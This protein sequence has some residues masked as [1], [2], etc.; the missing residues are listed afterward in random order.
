MDIQDGEVCIIDFKSSNIRKKEKA[1]K[2]TRESLQLAIYA[3][4]YQKI[5]GKIPD[6]VELHFLE[7]GLIG[8]AG[9]SEDDL[10]RTVKKIDKAAAGIRVRLYEAKPAYLACRYCAYEK[11]C[12]YTAGKR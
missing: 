6:R 12:P 2:R 10:N 1:D 3:L 9:L 4:A 7:S 5:Y 8:S 11:V